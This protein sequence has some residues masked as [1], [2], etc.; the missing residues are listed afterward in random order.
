MDFTPEIEVVTP[1]G[2]GSPRTIYN[3]T[4]NLPTALSMCFVPGRACS[5]GGLRRASRYGRGGLSS[6]HRP[7]PRCP[8]AAAVAS[9]SSARSQSRSRRW[10]RRSDS[11]A[12]IISDSEFGAFFTEACHKSSVSINT[13]F[14]SLKVSTNIVL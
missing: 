9:P 14:V 2:D 1:R 8:W 13:R 12:I 11:A 5:R 3:V 4:G 6:S 10:Q 7:C